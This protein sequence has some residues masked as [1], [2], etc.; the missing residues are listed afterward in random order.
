MSESIDFTVFLSISA[1][2]LLQVYFKF[3]QMI[4]E[5]SVASAKQFLKNP[6]LNFIIIGTTPARICCK[7]VVGGREDD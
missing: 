1:L 6:T 5:E 4:Y 2:N 3:L 7:I